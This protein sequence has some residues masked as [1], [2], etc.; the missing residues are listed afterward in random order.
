[1]VIG[2]GLI[3]PPYRPPSKRKW[4]RANQFGGFD[5]RR[6]LDAWPRRPQSTHASGLGFYFKSNPG[7]PEAG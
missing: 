3:E 4:W 6:A 2:Q 1:V 7:V 5:D